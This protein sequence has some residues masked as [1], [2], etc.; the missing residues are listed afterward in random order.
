MNLE[1][2]LYDEI[3]RLIFQI[4]EGMVA[5][6]DDIAVALGDK[7]SKVAVMEILNRKDFEDLKGKVVRT[8]DS[9]YK[10]FRNFSSTRP[11][12]ILKEFQ[13]VSS[14]KIIEKDSFDKLEFI[15]GVDVSYEDDLAYASFVIIDKNYRI[16]D[17]KF[18][19]CK[20]NFPYIPGYLSF[21]EGPP[22]IEV[23]KRSPDF[24]ILMVNGHGLAHPRFFGLASHVGLELDKPTIGVTQKRLV[25][26]MISH[27]KECSILIYRGRIVGAKLNIHGKKNLYVSVGHKMSLDTSIEIVKKFCTDLNLPEPLRVAHILSKNFGKNKGNI[28]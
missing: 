27:N 16:I 19:K 3:R 28:I 15:A 8:F 11:L 1:L 17:I 5:V 25:G 18:S 14:K 7:R 24:D 2:D 9:R 23:V 26:K 13:K 21:R 10:L 20:T 22:I 6:A 4:P 12:N